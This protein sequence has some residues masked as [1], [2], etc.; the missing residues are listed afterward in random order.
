MLNLGINVRREK[1]FCQPGSSF[2]RVSALSQ[3]QPSILFSAFAKINPF[4]ALAARRNLA[5]IHA[6]DSLRVKCKDE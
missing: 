4:A 3:R 2:A 5:S 6:Q 1:D